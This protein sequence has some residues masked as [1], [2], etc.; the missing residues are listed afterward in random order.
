MI[1]KVISVNKHNNEYNTRKDDLY[2]LE[3][4]K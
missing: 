4:N 2:S 1:V 3:I